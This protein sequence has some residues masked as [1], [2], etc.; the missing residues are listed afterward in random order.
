MSVAV[1]IQAAV[2]YCATVGAAAVVPADKTVVVPDVTAEIVHTP[3]PTFITVITVPTGKA[4]VAFVGILKLL[5]D[6]LFMVTST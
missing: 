4:V 3:A 1:L 2:L 5:A 6:A